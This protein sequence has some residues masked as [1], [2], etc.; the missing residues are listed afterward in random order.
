VVRVEQD[1]GGGLAIVVI[2]ALLD[3]G[4]LE[5][6]SHLNLRAAARALASGTG[7]QVAAVSWKHSDR[8]PEAEL[9]GARAPV[10]VPWVRSQLA[11]GKREFLFVPFFVSPQGAIGSALRGDL[12]ALARAA[13]GFSYT[14]SAGLADEGVLGP[15]LSDRVREVIAEK[16]L[17]RPAVV[18]VDH[19]GPSRV[20]AAL[21][22]AVASEVRSA[23]GEAVG[24][25]AAAS[26]ESPVGPEFAHN[27]P[28]FSAQ[29]GAPG[30]D[31]GDVV[32]A[33]LFLSPGRHAGPAG[34]LARIARAAENRT[35]G[36]RIHFTGLVGS[37]P[38]AAEA[39]TRGL[40]SALDNRAAAVR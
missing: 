37:H 24:P 1:S 33:P 35:P 32:V 28:L 15:I 29:L 13:G 2:V 14:F 39:L 8:I 16:G 18:V 22:D 12:D 19:G 30:F 3:N 7:V 38:L 5:A 10:L 17:R 6:A 34:D 40:K 11:L 31:R 26:L 21:R 20:S 27:Q 36:R 4:S 23:L 25:L 9:G